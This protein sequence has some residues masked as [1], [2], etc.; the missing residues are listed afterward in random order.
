M[1]VDIY[2]YLEPAVKSW[3]PFKGIFKEDALGGT[4]DFFDGEPNWFKDNKIDVAILGVPEERNALNKGCAEAPRMV[5]KWLYGM[6]NV[7]SGKR[8]ADVGDVKGNALNDRYLALK[9]VVEFFVSEGVFVLLIGGSQDLTLPACGF[10][11]NIEKGASNI[12]IVDAFLDID[13][14]GS[15]FSSSAFLHKMADDLEDKIN[16]ITVLGNQNYYCSPGQEQYM[17]DHF[18]PCVRLKD[19][20][21]NAIDGAEVVL[22]DS[23]FLSFDFLSI[24]QQPGLPKGGF[25]PNGFSNAEACRIF[26]Y[27]GASDVLKVAGLF[28]VDIREEDENK[29]SA[30]IAAQMLWHLLE[31]M[32]ARC[33]DYPFKPIVEYEQRAVFLEEFNENLYFYHNQN[34]D[35]WW[36]K[37]PSLHGKKI[38]ACHSNDY[39]RALEK[40]LP[41][42]WWRYFHKAK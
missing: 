21:G 41:E 38:V 39:E 32:G 16:E 27:A 33:N 37:V 22:R 28:N 7:S 6:R 26:W 2:H 17:K 13:I 29:N 10:I 35:R 1:L 9:E 11:N 18:F 19:L 15:D 40:D 31:G 20:K 14:E 23:I 42:V 30:I 12:S 36:L 34:N 25:M 4:I 5:R 3:T 8:I 24:E